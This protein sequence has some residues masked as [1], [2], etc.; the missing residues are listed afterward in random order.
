M[1]TNVNYRHY[2]DVVNEARAL[3]RRGNERSNAYMKS[4]LLILALGLALSATADDLRLRDGSVFR[5]TKI[6]ARKGDKVDLFVAGFGLQTV[7]FAQLMPDDQKA[8]LKLPLPR[9]RNARPTARRR[10]LQWLHAWRA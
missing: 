2:S 8:V 7:P 1:L 3:T 4:L 10:R 9:L 5:N 6:I